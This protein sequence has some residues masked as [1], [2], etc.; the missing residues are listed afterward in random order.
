VLPLKVDAA[1]GSEE[2]EPCRQ[3][4]D[5]ELP[6]IT[7]AA[8]ITYVLC[9]PCALKLAHDLISGV[10]ALRDGAP[11]ANTYPVSHGEGG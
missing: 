4:G 3:C 11:T 6:K 5:L 8:W 10:K 2:E 1:L 7:L 9:P